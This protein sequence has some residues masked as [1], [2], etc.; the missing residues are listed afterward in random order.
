VNQGVVVHICN[1]SNLGSRD[2][3]ISIGDK[4]VRPYAKNKAWGCIPV[5]T[6]TREAEEEGSHKV[7]VRSYLKNKLKAK[8]METWLK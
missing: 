3:T 4:L 8:G 1:P 6:A 5:F 2:R 7:S